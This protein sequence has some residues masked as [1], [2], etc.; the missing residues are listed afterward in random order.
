MYHSITFGT[1]NTWDDWH[2][3]PTSRPVV[4]PPTLKTKYVNI[5]GRNG[6]LDLT[7]YLTETPTF[8]NSE[9]SWEFIVMNDYHIW[10]ELYS[11]IMDYL[12]GSS[13]NAI[14]EDDP[15]YYYRGR[16]SVSQWKSDPKYSLITIDYMLE[17]SKYKLSELGNDKQKWDDSDITMTDTNL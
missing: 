17:P 14:L 5:P 13:L 11:E 7:E 2:L 12:H 10:S 16:F 1:K 15:L 3:V 9:G 6:V 4:N 8:N